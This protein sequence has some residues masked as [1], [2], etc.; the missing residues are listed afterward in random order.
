MRYTFTQNSNAPLQQYE[1][2]A[3][4]HQAATCGMKV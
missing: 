3:K 2:T 1:I 4:I